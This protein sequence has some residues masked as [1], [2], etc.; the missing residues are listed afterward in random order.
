M[1]K[2]KDLE[3]LKNTV[4][5]KD[6]RKNFEEK[7]KETPVKKT[8]KDPLKTV[9]KTPMKMK[10][11]NLP[12]S[13]HSPRSTG[14]SSPRRFHGSRDRGRGD[15]G[16][17]EVSR[18]EISEKFGKNLVS[19]KENSARQIGRQDQHPEETSP[20]MDRQVSFTLTEFKFSAAGQPNLSTSAKLR[21]CKGKCDWCTPG[22]AGSCGHIQPIGGTVTSQGSTGIRLGQHGGQ[23]QPLGQGS[24]GQKLS[25]DQGEN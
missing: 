23:E 24:L 21:V 11:L 4:S 10:T 7:K 16:K 8:R 1:L 2:K 18:L 15:G 14:I 12:F 9:K 5:V 25:S 3:T 19:R 17:M 6:R 22:Q 13:P 20:P